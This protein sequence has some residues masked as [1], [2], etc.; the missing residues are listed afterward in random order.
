[1]L[2]QKLPKN[3]NYEQESFFLLKQTK[4]KYEVGEKYFFSEDE[5]NEYI[6]FK[7][8]K[9]IQIFKLKDIPEYLCFLEE[10]L[11]KKTWT[12]IKRHRYEQT[13]I[14]ENKYFEDMPVTFLLFSSQPSYEQIKDRL[15]HGIKPT[16]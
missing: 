12:D 9:E 15:Y 13:P 4:E 6:G 5:N 16:K 14:D 2:F 3:I 7:Y 10:N 11:D 1:M 8:L